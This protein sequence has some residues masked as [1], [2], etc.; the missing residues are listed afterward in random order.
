M[1]NFHEYIINRKG[2]D[3]YGTGTDKQR[4]RKTYYS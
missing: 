3:A 4:K 1:V 2:R